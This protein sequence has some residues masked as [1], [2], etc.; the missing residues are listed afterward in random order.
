MPTHE[1][2]IKLWLYTSN[3]DGRFKAF[4]MWGAKDRTKNDPPHD[5]M[6]SCLEGAIWI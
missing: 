4:Q 3:T 2:L 6:L 1:R 5:S